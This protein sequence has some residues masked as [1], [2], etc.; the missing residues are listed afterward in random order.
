MGSD[1]IINTINDVK[2]ANKNIERIK[3]DYKNEPELL[4]FYLP[5]AKC[6]I[7]EL[8]NHLFYLISEELETDFKRGLNNTADLWIRLEGKQFIMGE[9]PIGVIGSYLQKLNNAN[10]HAVKLIKDS[11]ESLKLIADNFLEISSFNLIATDKGSLKLGLK[12]PGLDEFLTETKEQQLRLFDDAEDSDLLNKLEDITRLNNLSIDGFKLLIKTLASV[13][14]ESLFADLQERYNEKD[15]MKLLHY[16]KELVPSS[17]SPFDFIWFEGNNLGISSSVLKTDKSTRK[18]L[19]EREK[20]LKQDTEYI[21]G[22]GWV[23][24][25]DLDG[26]TCIIRPFHY[27]NNNLEQIECRFSKD[28]IS[29]NELR[30]L[31]DEYVS[32]NG[33]L[34]FSQNYVPVRIEVEEI[35]KEDTQY[36]DEE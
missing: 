34:V 17:R 2:K 1:K 3:E 30:M 28:N 18:L 23:R 7:N 5:S 13:D 19:V 32:L 9:G 6:L 20:K 8:E 25:V 36:D 22:K 26:L 12:I 27:K 14:D 4:D 10:G 15:V 35:S 29:S 24:A 21:T 33:F 11:K 16:A 31:L